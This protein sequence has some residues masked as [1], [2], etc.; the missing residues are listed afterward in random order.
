MHPDQQEEPPD[1]TN[2]DDLEPIEGS[3]TQ[4][5]GDIGKYRLK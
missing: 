4:G 5:E 1:T 3:G 2:E